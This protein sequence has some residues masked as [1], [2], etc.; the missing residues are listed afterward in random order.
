MRTSREKIFARGYAG[1]ARIRLALRCYLALRLDT[2]RKK[3][4][5][6]ARPAKLKPKP[7]R[8]FNNTTAW[9]QS[10]EI[11][12]KGAAANGACPISECNIDNQ[13]ASKL[14]Q[15]VDYSRFAGKAT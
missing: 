11:C 5:A 1:F 14:T 15:T 3:T 7:Q 13:I 9:L 12:G 10:S 2:P 8:K 4:E 6:L